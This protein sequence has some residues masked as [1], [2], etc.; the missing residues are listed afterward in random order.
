MAIKF[1]N[2]ATG[3]TEAAGDNSTKIATTAY[4]D[5]AAAAVPI[6]DYVTL[7]T[8]QTISGAKTFSASQTIFDG[9]V[10]IGTTSPTQKLD[11]NGNIGLSGNGTGNRWILLNE[12]NTY[13]GTLRIQ[14]GAGSAAYGGAINMYGHSHA[15]NPGDVAV[16]ISSGSGGSFRVNS[17]G[18][19]T[20]TDLFIVKSSG[21]VGIGTTSPAYKLDVESGNIRVS[22]SASGEK[23]Y[24]FYEESGGPTGAT[25]G[26]DGATNSL[27]L[28]T[29][30]DNNDTI[31]QHLVIPRATGNVG[32]G[33]TSPNRSL[34][35]I[36][37]VAIDNS[38]SPSGGLLVSPDGTS[39]K[40]YS[41]T[42]NATSSAHPLDFIS[43]SSTSMRIDSA[44][45]VGIGTTSPSTTLQLTKAN[46]EVL[47][48]QPAW[49]KGILE[50]TD[51]SAYNAGTGA[52]IVFRKKRDST[53]NQVTVGAIAGEGV[54]GDSR[55][56]FWTGTAA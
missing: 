21:N 52:T 4:V 56:S 44:G 51:T 48:N 43:G 35:V 20:G 36:G 53:G 25:V 47:A 18:I 23:S 11:V 50:I 39:N 1:L 45:N 41:R 31:S 16:G 34:H 27:F 28:G 40:V 33:T 29:T 22:S 14:A 24:T 26:Y 54:A 15:T 38:T 12:T 42:G 7:A 19:D 10:G 17:T 30:D 46:T 55:L 8:T 3:I 13:A 32:I 9:N 37:Q 5:A 6:G 49:P 2:T